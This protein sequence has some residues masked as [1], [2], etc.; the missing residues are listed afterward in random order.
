[1]NVGAWE[2]VGTALGSGVV[3]ALITYRLGNRKQ[4]ES[5][6]N[7]LIKEYKGLV[8]QYKNQVEK[9]EERVRIVE[10]EIKAKDSELAHLKS[11]LMI[12]ESSHGDVPV[13]IWLKDTSGVMLYLNDEYERQILNPIGKTREDYIGKTDAEVWPEDVAKSFREH[14]TEVMRK[15]KPL[16]FQEEW[17]GSNDVAYVGEVVKYPRFMNNTGRSRTVIGI[18]GMIIGAKKL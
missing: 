10:R 18:G 15:K 2:L 4:D 3:T 6:F 5:D 14:D 8:I 17:Y 7:S 1:M 11:Q 12:F 13:P 16:T 9:L